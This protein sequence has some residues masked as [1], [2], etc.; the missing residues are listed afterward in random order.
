MS[1]IS[2]KLSKRDYFYDRFKICKMIQ[3]LQSLYLA[4]VLI[5][6]LLFFG[7]SV[8]KCVDETGQTI[9]VMLNG[10]LTDQGGQSFAMV[11]ALWPV[12]VILIALTLLSIVTILMFRNRK[13]QLKLAGAI[14]FIAAILII[15]LFIYAYIVIHSYR[16]KIVPVLKMA[17][18]VLVLIFSVLAYRGILKDDRLVRSYDRLR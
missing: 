10:M 9:R 14:I 1:F 15:V 6:S 7:G 8:F 2:N 11:T 3:R 13:I 4:L 18:P 5:L 12:S 16:L 17:V